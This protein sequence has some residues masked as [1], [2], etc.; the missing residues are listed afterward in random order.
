[1]RKT[2]IVLALII[3]AS[4]TFAQPEQPNYKQAI[5]NFK[6]YFNDND[7]DG[8]FKMFSPEVKAGLPLDKTK[9][10]VTQ[11]H[12]QIGNLK[13]TT[14]IKYAQTAGVY[15]ADYD[16]ATLL[17]NLSLNGLNQIDGLYFN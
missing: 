2:A 14:F 5:G 1:M 17:I 11:M 9:E 10:L 7:A 3:I 16:K 15:K 4:V 8:L 13:E 6:Q 12:A